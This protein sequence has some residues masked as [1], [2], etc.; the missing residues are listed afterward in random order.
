MPRLIKNISARVLDFLESESMTTWL[1]ETS[2]GDEDYFELTGFIGYTQ[3]F[4][5][6]NQVDELQPI[7]NYG[8]NINTDEL[9]ELNTEIDC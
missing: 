4:K 6:V 8:L 7:V 5:F 1:I 9:F 2:F 3:N